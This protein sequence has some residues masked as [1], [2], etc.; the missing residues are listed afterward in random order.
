M[1][2]RKSIIEEVE[3][4]SGAEFYIQYSSVSGETATISFDGPV[5]NFSISIKSAEVDKIIAAL[6]KAK[7][8][9]DAN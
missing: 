4:E 2:I 5:A 1:S 3:L 8:E 9:A 7:G 6:Q